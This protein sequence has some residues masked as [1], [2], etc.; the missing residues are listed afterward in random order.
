LA[1][2]L[3]DAIANIAGYT[4]IGIVLGALGLLPAI[5]A[6]LIATLAESSQFKGVHFAVS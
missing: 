5:A 1:S 3:T 2:K 6:A 4:P